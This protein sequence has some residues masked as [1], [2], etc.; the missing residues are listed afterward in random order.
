MLIGCTKSVPDEPPAPQADHIV[1]TD[2]ESS[3]DFSAEGGTWQI[4]FDATA[5]WTAEQVI[6]I[7]VQWYHFTPR[8]GKAGAGSVTVTVL[9]N[10]TDE[11]RSAEIRLSAGRA[12]QILSITQQAGHVELTTENEVRAFLERLYRDT[13]G[14]NW[15]FNA[16][17]CSDKP[18]SEWDGVRYENGLLSLWLGEKYLKG[19]MDLSGC[20]A[21]VELRCAKNSLTK[22]DV[23]GCPLLKE[24]DCTSNEITELNVSGCSSLDRLLCGY[25]QLTHLDLSTV[26]ALTYLRCDYNRISAIDISACPWIATLNVAG[27]GLSALNV[28]GR[29]ELRS[30]FCYENRLT[31]LDLSGCEWLDLVNC[32]T[33]RLTELHLTGCSR[34]SDL[35]CYDNRLER[36]DLKPLI[37]ILGGLYCPGNRLTELDCDRSLRAHHRRERCGYEGFPETHPSGLFGQ[38]LTKDRPEGL[39]DPAGLRMRS[40]RTSGTRPHHV[41]NALPTGLHVEPADGARPDECPLA[42]EALLPGQSDSGGD[43]RGVRPSAGIRA[44]CPLRIPYRDGPN[45]GRGAHRSYRHGPRLVVSRRTGERCPH[46]L[47]IEP[48]RDSN[49]EASE[50]TISLDSQQ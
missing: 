12:E 35:Y 10:T 14:E 6:P 28:V 17:W 15:R 24:I 23:S 37:A 39:F 49:V 22:I 36:L 8:L 31:Q 47:I 16:N 43:S 50:G 18:I 19:Q 5:D 42:V 2:G 45:N 3:R 4:D 44:R 32:G 46:T 48:V 27:N 20:T 34:L 1:L 29:T 26:P 33:N 41:R 13:D 21:L 11:T 30:L 40:E 9:P 25:N 7:A 38:R